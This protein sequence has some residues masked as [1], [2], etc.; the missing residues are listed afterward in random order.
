MIDYRMATGFEAL[1]GWLFLTGAY[2]RLVE[3]VSFGLKRSGLL[4]QPED[5]GEQPT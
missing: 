4:T 1:V 3:L 5:K 2:E